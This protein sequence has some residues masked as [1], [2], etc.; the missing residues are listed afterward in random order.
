MNVNPPLDPVPPGVVTDTEPD[1]P[2]P[3]VAWMLVGEITVSEAAAVPPN[4]TAVAPVKFAPLMV[5]TVPA[6]AVLGVNPSREG[7][8]MNVNPTND[9]LPPGPVTTTV[10]E[11]PGP[12]TASMLVG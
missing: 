8:G 7:P 10:P 9:P 3:T 1:V 2:L 12:T 5:T 11:V 4:V 6:A